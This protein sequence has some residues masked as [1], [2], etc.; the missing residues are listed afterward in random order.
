VAA[1]VPKATRI[2]GCAQRHLC[3]RHVP[4]SVAVSGLAKK[5]RLSQSYKKKVHKPALVKSVTGSVTGMDNALKSVTGVGQDV[6]VAGVLHATVLNSLFACASVSSAL[7]AWA[8][9]ASASVD[10]GFGRSYKLH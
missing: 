2:G 1:V 10:S 6:R 8:S 3:L 9:V 5:Y 7:A 4:L